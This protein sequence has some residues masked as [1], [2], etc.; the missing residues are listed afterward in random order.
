[1]KVLVADDE[2]VT[3]TLFSHWLTTWG[4]EVVAVTNGTAALEALENDS[5]I[6][7]ALVDWMMPGLSG[8]EVVSRVRARESDQ[9]VYIMLVTARDDTA[10]LVEGLDSGADDY[11]KKPCNPLELKV[12]LR[13][14]RRMVE[15]QEQLVRAREALRFEAT[16]DALTGLLNRRAAERVLEQE[17]SRSNRTGTPLAVLMIDLDRFKSINDRYGHAGG[18][19]VLV[20]AARCLERGVRSY[21]QVARLGGEEF[22]VILPGCTAHDATLVAERLRESMRAESVP[23]AGGAISFTASVGIASHLE[24]AGSGVE[25]LLSAADAALYRAKRLGRDRSELA[26]VSSSGPADPH[27]PT[28]SQVTPQT[29]SL[30]PFHSLRAG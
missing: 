4:Y 28:E 8:V 3:R 30:H 20:A 29:R 18:D 17:Y 13:A 21:D 5:S 1:V 6:R 25:T 9:Y 12:R 19:N 16:H 14:G 26:I 27:N 10:D 23:T 15:L 2:P 22:L 24:P 11:I 7:L